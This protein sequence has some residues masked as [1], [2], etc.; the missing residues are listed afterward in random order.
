MLH[1]YLLAG[2]GMI[3]LGSHG[4][5]GHSQLHGSN[6]GDALPVEFSSNV[7]DL[8]A[9]GGKPVTFGPDAINFLKYH[10]LSPQ[11]TCFF[12][13]PAT[14]KPGARV[15]MQVDG[16][17]FMVA[18]EYGPNKAR[19]L[20]ILGAP[21]GDARQGQIPFWQDGDWYPDPAR[22]PLVGEPSG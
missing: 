8:K 22:C 3:V 1:D 20:C 16:K 17:P 12:L 2:G 14:P 11:A 21:M 15:L 13:H 4:A 9:T 18:G 5:Y 10:A 19:I 6:L 7:M